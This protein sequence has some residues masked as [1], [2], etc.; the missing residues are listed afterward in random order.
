MT[1]FYSMQNLTRSNVGQTINGLEKSSLTNT[2]RQMWR[3]LHSSR[4]PRV[5]AYLLSE[6]GSRT[7]GSILSVENQK[8]LAI[9]RSGAKVVSRT[10]WLWL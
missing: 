8:R 10:V 9:L 7:E 3:K 2:P 6:V 5:H 1:S 4:I